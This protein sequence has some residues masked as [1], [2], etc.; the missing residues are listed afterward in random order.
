MTED[1]S[2][3]FGMVALEVEK[4]TR[5]ENFRKFFAFSA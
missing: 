5:I 3:E 2:E 4:S 1:L